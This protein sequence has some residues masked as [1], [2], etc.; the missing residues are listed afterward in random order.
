[1]KCLNKP[2]YCLICVIVLTGSL[3]TAQVRRQ[4][5]IQTGQLQPAEKVRLTLNDA[6][7]ESGLQQ[8]ADTLVICP[9]QF[10][11]AL[12]PW[13]EYRQQQGHRILVMPPTASAYGVKRQ[14]REIATHGQLKT[15]VLIGDTPNADRR[16]ILT[17]VP[18]DYVPARVI[19]KFGPEPEIATDNTYADIDD[20]GL[21]DLAIGRMPVDSVGS[22]ER[23][24]R[25][26]INYEAASGGE[27][28]RRINL[29]AGTGGFGQLPDSV[30]ERTS[31]R[32]IS[33]LIPP[34]YSTSMTYANWSSAY[35]PDPRE[36]ISVTLRRLNEGSLFWVYMGHGHP[37]R[38]DYVRTP[39]GGFPMFRE[40]DI[41]LIDCQKG[42][43]IALMLACYTGAF[44]F[45]KDCLAEKMV[46]QTGGPIAV[47]CGSRVT[48]PAGMSLL[49]VGLIEEYFTG[50]R[51]TLGEMFL[52][53]K[54][55]LV[56]EE[57]GGHDDLNRITPEYESRFRD[58]IRLLGETLGPKESSL[59]AEASEHVHLFHLLGDPLLRVQRPRQ[60][61]LAAETSKEQDKLTVRGIS[62]HP[63]S[64]M[65][66]LVYCRDRF[67]KRPPRRPEF[68]WD[69]ETLDSYREV[70]EQ[71][72]CRTVSVKQM[73][74]PAGEFEFEL[75]IPDWAKGR[76]VVRG[77]L[78]QP[79]Q[80]R[81]ALGASE[82]NIKR[83]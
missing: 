26:I 69:D 74:V 41:S 57:A 34:E 59:S 72:N 13:L 63:G 65:V 36:F 27:W 8:V 32:L 56:I 43:P 21:P 64:L 77:Y 49:S 78:Q 40:R 28:Q 16:S 17:T 45:P 68:K 75:E 14:I 62:P 1:M 9:D 48:M 7:L 80:K 30:I 79:D 70:Y 53:A 47:L 22:L 6:T 71:S 3:A 60:I 44:D 38:L 25:K 15:V 39:I 18:T 82:L 37:N 55:K 31:R 81:Y 76:C 2:S 73:D 51:E 29:V 23:Q 35:C 58:T 24:V 66:E 20:D 61:E 50:N 83:R 4:A 33:D 54:R 42:Q 46:D 52:Q 10:V 11:P 12:K 5:P 67:H 19:A